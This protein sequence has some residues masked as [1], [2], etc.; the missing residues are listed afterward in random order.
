M[1]QR[2]RQTDTGR[3]QRPRLRI[4]SRSK[5]YTSTASEWNLTLQHSVQPHNYTIYVS[6]SRIN[7]A[8]LLWDCG[9]LDTVDTRCPSRLLYQYSSH[10]T[11][12]RRRAPGERQSVMLYQAQL[13]QRLTTPRQRRHRL[14][15]WAT[16]IHSVELQRVGII[17]VTGLGLAIVPLCRGTGAPLRRTQAPPGP[18]E[19]F[20]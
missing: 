9:K 19:I 4:A 20:W 10:R 12:S 15:M 8:S 14:Q 7:A 6:V 17:I 3:H 11:E 18:F 16:P 5:N 13:T 2:D 1:H